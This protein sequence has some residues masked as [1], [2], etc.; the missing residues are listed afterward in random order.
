MPRT[1]R[2][3]TFLAS[4][5]AALAAVLTTLLVLELGGT[6]QSRIVAA[7]S[8]ATLA[9]LAA[10]VAAWRAAWVA[11]A[12]RAHRLLAAMR[13]AAAGDLSARAD[14][15][16]A[17]EFAELAAAFNRAAAAHLDT[18][19]ALQAERDR[20]AAVLQTAS[21]A[22]LAVD[23]QE[24]VRYANPAAAALFGPPAAGDHL[25]GRTLVEVT[26]DHELARLVA[27]PL[28]GPRQAL[29]EHGAARLLLRALAQPLPAGQEWSALLVC[30]DLTEVRRIEDLRREFVA[31]VTHE[32][33]TPI[34]A[35]RAA[36]E[37]LEG[38][39]LDDRPAAED[40]VRRIIEEAERLDGLVGEL[41]ELGRLESRRT[42]PRRDPFD[43]AALLAEVA[44]RA[45][46]LAE[47]AG[48]E[49][50][51]EASADLPTAWGDRE[52]LQRALMNLVHNAVKFTPSG[53]RVMLAASAE[54]GRLLLSVSDT[55][56]G[57]PPERLPRVFE[58]FY[59]GDRTRGGGAGL[60]LAIVKHTARA[61]GG[62]VR[63]S[64]A[65]GSGSTFTIVLP[66][67]V[68]AITGG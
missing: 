38:G 67:P 53:G 66:L 8:A 24:R 51:V 43:P 10:G 59:K 33:R 9:G 14:D 57:I 15:R 27:P 32:L 62:D 39:A 56:I 20:L 36:A 37:T 45:R 25:L 30:T 34:A 55:G 50:A 46:P 5:A 19:R 7:S 29:V 31:N 23:H 11:P 26:R 40:F 3:A 28:E 2:T 52:R 58:R 64:S 65:P 61:H 47:R 41:L 68:P 12:R 13:R 18:V 1:L 4:L 16:A 49:I 63:V 44:R 35:V 60:G 22:V 42:L 6:P 21:D 54:D 48:L 17:D